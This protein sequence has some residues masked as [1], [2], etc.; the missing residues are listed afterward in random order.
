MVPWAPWSWG[1][2]GEGLRAEL[3][4]APSTPAPER[5]IV[6]AFARW[7]LRV[8]CATLGAVV[9]KVIVD[10]DSLDDPEMLARWNERT[11]WKK[12]EEACP[13]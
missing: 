7:G 8:K 6:E 11:P 12:I 3:G 5:E 1:R 9:G 2:L 13:T 4:D 10:P